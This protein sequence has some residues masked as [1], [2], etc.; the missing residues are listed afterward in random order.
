MDI[1]GIGEAMAALLLEKGLVKDVADIYK[2]TREDLLTLERI[3]EKS[4]DN[5]INA[6]NKSKN[7]SLARLIFALG[8]RHIGEEMAGVLAQDFNDLDGLAEATREQLMSIPSVGP[9]IAESVVTFFGQKENRNIIERLKKAGVWPKAEV[10]KSAELPLSGNEFVITGRLAAFSREEAEAKV[11]ALGG[12]A[13]DNVTRNTAYVVVGEEP[14]GSKLTRAQ[15]L[16]TKQITEAEF[17][18]L[19]GETQ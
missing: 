14:G 13:K 5:L 12:T 6:I 3:G 4:A 7:Q 15:E 1:R 8:I 16:G 2:I 19:I 10:V 11:K 18:R 17:L 9:K